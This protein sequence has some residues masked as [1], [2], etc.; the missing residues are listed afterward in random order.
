M[1]IKYRV[2]E[3]AKDFNLASKDITEILTEYATT[4]KNHMQVL[5][6]PELDLIFEYLTQHHE[7]ESLE[8]VFRDDKPAQKPTAEPEKS[9][10]VQSAQTP[11]RCNP[12]HADVC[13]GPACADTR[14]AQSREAPYAAEAGGEA[15]S[16]HPRQHRRQH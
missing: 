14:R 9:A 1:M 15:R 13:C 7:I 16:G 4:P 8:E 2:H 11:C 6:I 5:E 12:A 3:V 10:A